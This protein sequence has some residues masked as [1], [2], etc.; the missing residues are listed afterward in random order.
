MD[1]AVEQPEGLHRGAV[2]DLLHGQP[3]DVLQLLLKG[4]GDL[5]DPLSH[6]GPADQKCHIIGGRKMISFGDFTAGV[7]SP[8]THLQIRSWGLQWSTTGR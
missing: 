5:H 3:G 1:V 4:T 8:R 2:V 7:G 6:N